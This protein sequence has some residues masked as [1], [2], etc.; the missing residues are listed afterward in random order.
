MLDFRESWPTN[1]ENVELLKGSEV[2]LLQHIQKSSEL[3]SMFLVDDP[4]GTI[5]LNLGTINIYEAKIQDFLKRMLVLCYITVG[6]PLREP[7]YLFIL[8]Y[9]TSRQKHIIIWEKFV[10]IFI[11]YHKGQQQSGAYKDNIRFLP[12]DLGDLLL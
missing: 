6:Q 5:V 10:M 11:Q 1:P 12:K 3:R 8:W 2:T 4:D 9:N 7:E